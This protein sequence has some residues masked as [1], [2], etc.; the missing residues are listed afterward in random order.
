MGTSPSCYIQVP[1]PPVSN[2]IQ[3]LF[4]ARGREISHFVCMFLEL[5]LHLKKSSDHFKTLC[6]LKLSKNF[7]VNLTSPPGRV[8][9]LTFNYSSLKCSQVDIKSF[10]SFGLWEFLKRVK[11]FSLNG[12]A[13]LKSLQKVVFHYKP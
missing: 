4:K 8:V 13:A 12:V 7:D 9:N 6:N 3:I 11:N 2:L 1:P 10:R 5:L